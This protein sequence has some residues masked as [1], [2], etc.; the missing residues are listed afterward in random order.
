M[1][2]YKNK[3]ILA[4]LLLPSIILIA[5]MIFLPVILNVYY[6]LFKWTA[7]SRTMQFVGLEYYVKMFK[8][9]YVWLAFYN[10]VKYAVVSIIFQAFLGLIIAH[11][12]NVIASKKVAVTTRVIIFI[13]AVVS[14]TAI[15]LLWVIIY[16]PSIGFLDPLMRMV[17]LGGFVKDWLGNKQT[18]MMAV[19]MVSQWQYM[20]EMVMLYTVGLQNIPV[21]L[22]ESSKID[23]ANP[24]QTFFKI[25][26]PMI[27]ETALMN[28]MITIIGAF[29]VFD[30]VYVMTS[31]GPGRATETLAT[32]LYKTGFRKDN[33]GYACA[34]GVLM[35]VVTF[36]FAAIELKMFNVKK[37]M[38]GDES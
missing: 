14:I 24:I 11:I 33:M 29:M 4:I 5:V 31:G 3:K 25:T 22:Y 21:E 27:K 37:A 30:E 1:A 18:A 35:F 26:I 15:G 23:G 12:L 34:I 9:N 2:I 36:I 10:N 16:N 7:Y 19:I 20:G 13:P 32:T 38:V 17:G 8:D 6:S 28:I